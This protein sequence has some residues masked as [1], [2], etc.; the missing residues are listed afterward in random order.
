MNAD[1]RQAEGEQAEHAHEYGHVIQANGAVANRLLH[2][3]HV[4]NGL[5]AIHV[6]DRGRHGGGQRERIDAGGAD[7]DVHPQFG[8]LCVGNVES[9]S[10]LP[11]VGAVDDVAD[12]TDDGKPGV[13]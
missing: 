3:A 12:N 13:L 2:R 9:R 6:T 4:G 1:N 7:C 8:S 5:L 10:R 11:F